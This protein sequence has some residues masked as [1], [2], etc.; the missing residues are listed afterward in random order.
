MRRM[1]R[2]T[3]AA[4][5]GVLSLS[6]VAAEGAA[7]TPDRGTAHTEL[8]GV[9]VEISGIGDDSVLHHVLGTLEPVLPLGVLDLST[10]ASNDTDGDR[11]AVGG[12]QPY[13]R[14]GVVPLRTGDR[15]IGAV[16]AD[17][18]GEGSARSPDSGIGN[19]DSLTDLLAAA[20]FPIEANARADAMGALSSVDA[21]LAEVDALLGG[22]GLDLEVTEVSSAVGQ[23]GA[24]AVQGLRVTGFE[25]T[26]GDLI[27]LEV[28]EQL[29]LGALNDLLGE[30]PL[31]L[32]GDLDA[33]VTGVSDGLAA[34]PGALSD[35]TAAGDALASSTA[36][37]DLD[38][39]LG[40]F[41][42]V[43]ELERLWL[44]LDDLTLTDLTTAL[45]DLTALE[46][47][48]TAVGCTPDLTLT[49]LT[50]LA[51]EIDRLKA[52][53]EA[54]L[55]ALAL[56]G[57]A[58]ALDLPTAVDTLGTWIS[59]RAARVE[60]L[61]GAVEDAADVL[62]TTLDALLADV[63]LLDGLLAELDGLLPDIAALDLLSVS[64]LDVEF[65]ATATDEL[66]TSRAK[67]ACNPVDLRVLDT[68][69]AT[70]DCSEGLDAVSPVADAISAAISGSDGLVAD[71]LGAL[72]LSNAV[73]LGD[74][75]LALL[76]DVVE[77]VRRDG[78]YLVAEASATLLELVI[79]SLTIDPTAV[80][81][82]LPDLGLPTDLA[83]T[84]DG[85]IAQVGAAQTDLGALDTSPL[86]GTDFLDP[87]EAS[88]SAVSTSLTSA[89][90]DLGVLTQ[91]SGTVEMLEGAL[92]DLDALSFGDLTESV[93]TPGLRLVLDPA[94]TAEFAVASAGGSTPAP[95][96]DPGPGPGDPRLPETGGGL[97]V[98]GLL[99]IGA[100]EA[101]R[102]RR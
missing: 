59:G 66:E 8:L 44:A 102:R 40:V 2:L 100:A 84:I 7:A 48:L 79:P 42:Q 34:V 76:P 41:D 3:A 13:A 57:G 6:L 97:L 32:S 96:P 25:V 26:L 49:D 82:G 58:P 101:L 33:A 18:R 20:I 80:T 65:L 94:S 38:G 77:R 27:P 91:V 87:V 56:P 5:A 70:P 81:G 63:G 64:A 61:A 37:S 23:E 11:N 36:I 75:R 89:T 93:S 14:A 10:Y 28:L 90:D 46:P 45:A 1:S 83:A 99:G 60:G 98:L 19:L 68:P 55:D 12:G 54:E 50:A 51:A 47:A 24:S 92:A 16:E 86:T 95:D 35:L 67:F 31:G 15:E 78:D 85:V 29:P 17:S 71:V 74:L 62:R 22:I 43:E 73:A 4:L 21:A 72:P 30:L 39:A 9:E 53:L 69:F 88:L 52:C